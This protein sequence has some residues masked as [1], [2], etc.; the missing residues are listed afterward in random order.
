MIFRKGI[1][2]GRRKC[3]GWLGGPD[4]RHWGG[5][6]NQRGQWSRHGQTWPEGWDVWET[7]VLGLNPLQPELVRVA[8]DLSH[9]G[10]AVSCYFRVL[11]SI[12]NIN[13][14]HHSQ[15][16]WPGYVNSNQLTACLNVRMSWSIWHDPAPEMECFRWLWKLQWKGMEKRKLAPAITMKLIVWFCIKNK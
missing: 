1:F 2:R 16:W 15:G 5:E 10:H 14:H 11:L 6:R 7:R 8:W 3:C 13:H 4:W 9:L 12:F